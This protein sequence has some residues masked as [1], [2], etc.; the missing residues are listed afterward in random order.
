[1][2]AKDRIIVALDVDEPGKAIF[3]VKELSPHVRCFKIGL[4]LIYAMLRSI[5]V[6]FKPGE[7]FNNVNEI[8]ELF[9][10]L[11]KNILWDG[12][13]DD[14][15]NT[16]AG[17]SVEIK[18]IGVKMFNLH[19]SAGR[20]AIRQA[21]ANKGDAL[22]LGVTV[23][24]SLEGDDC[25]EIFGGLPQFVVLR[26]A[27]MLREEKADGLIC[28]PKELGI[29]K[30]NG[31]Q[32]LIKVTP[33]VRP[34]WAQ[35]KVDDQSK[36]RQMTPAEAIEAGADYLVIG[37]PITQPPKGIGSSVE[38]AKRIAEEIDKALNLPR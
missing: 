28:S 1:M 7:V 25:R 6:P 17:A 9:E 35:K 5:I 24:T 34:L 27:E 23:L 37:R 32:D 4:Q 38:A 10:S 26:F 29:L 15:P 33:N 12:K 22:V 2:E 16:V 31:Y 14:I 36:E 3:L 11:D 8:K 20:E 30:K 19:A 13:L 21:V 18:R